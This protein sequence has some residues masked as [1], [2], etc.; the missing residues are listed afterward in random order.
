[1]IYIL[2]H[3]LQRKGVNYYLYYKPGK[4]RRGFY[5]S[6]SEGNV[7]PMHHSLNKDAFTT[8]YNPNHDNSKFLLEPTTSGLDTFLIKR[9]R[10]QSKCLDF[11]G[12]LRHTRGHYPEIGQ[13]TCSSATQ[14]KFIEAP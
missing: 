8:R 1:M 9:E 13:A 12:Y 10:D 3:K 5:G 4:T 2:N 7:D 6:I 11:R 14:W